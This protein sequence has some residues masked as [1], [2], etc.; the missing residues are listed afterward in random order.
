MNKNIKIREIVQEDHQLISQAF[1]E[2]GWN[3][4][5]EQYERYFQESLTGQRVVLLAH[6]NEDF[7]GYVTLVWRSEYQAFQEKNIPEIV[8]LNVL[9][10]YQQHGIGTALMDAI[11]KLAR[12]RSN[13]VGLGVGMTADYG[14]AQ[15]LY[16]Q[17]GY[18]PDGRGLHHKGNPMQF[19]Y[20]APV[21]DDLVLYFTKDLSKDPFDQAVTFLY[22]SDLIATSQFYEEI[23]ELPLVR[24]QAVCRIYKAS[25][26]GYLGFC[27][28][29]EAPSSQGIILTLVTESVDTWHDLLL[30]KDVEITKPPTHNPKYQIYHFFFKDPNGYTL[31]IQRFDKPLS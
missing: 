10:K 6:Q 9:K 23:L 16:P 8:D 28:H 2:Q 14:P 7:A 15:R 30:T 5:K 4:P 17:L 20:Q 19:G 26:N 11:E 1:T 18:V 13:I 27:T 3:K 12:N 25:P 29:L 21:D 31:E 24:D 22:T